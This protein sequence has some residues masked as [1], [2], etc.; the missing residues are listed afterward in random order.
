M[1]HYYRISY[2]KD[3]KEVDYCQDYHGTLFNAVNHACRLGKITGVKCL[4]K[5]H[6]KHFKYLIKEV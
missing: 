5:K 1:K 3:G 2:S 6:T 4:K